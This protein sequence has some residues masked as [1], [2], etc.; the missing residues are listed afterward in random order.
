MW[1]KCLLEVFVGSV[2][3]FSTP[4]NSKYPGTSSTWSISEDF[5]PE[6]LGIAG[7]FAVPGPGSPN[8]TKVHCEWIGVPQ[9]GTVM[10]LIG[11]GWHAAMPVYARKGWIENLV[12]EK[13]IILYVSG[14]SMS[15]LC[16]RWSVLFFFAWG[17]QLWILGTT[18]PFSSGFQAISAITS[19]P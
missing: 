1:W 13:K 7:A 5:G 12:L 17:G 18:G 16:L 10:G 14:K 3:K 9:I 15:K 2:C 8:L 6:P 19:D 4:S 11:Q